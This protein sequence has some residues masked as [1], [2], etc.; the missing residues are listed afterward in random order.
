MAAATFS[1]LP[2]TADLRARV[3][4]A[5]LGA[6]YQAA[7]DLVRD[8]VVGASPVAARETRTVELGEGDE[9][10]RF[11]RFVRELVY[12]YD[13]EGFLPLAVELDGAVLLHGELFD[14]ERHVSE[15]QIKA[16]TR[17]GYRFAT[18]AGGSEA[19]LLFDL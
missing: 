19:E 11:H 2:H 8:I 16:V 5:D 1:Y 7:A 14:A 9:A 15:R 18:N 6:L 17:H 13:A 3:E 12:L 10:E 4:G